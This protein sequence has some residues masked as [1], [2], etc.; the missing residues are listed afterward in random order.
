[1]TTTELAKRLDDF[2]KDYDPYEYAH[3]DWSVEQTE[4][5]IRLSPES[6]ISKLLDILEDLEAR[7]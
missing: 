7:G 3:N 4:M 2:M 1:M 5:S 6:V